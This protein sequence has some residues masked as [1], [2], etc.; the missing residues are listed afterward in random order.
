MVLRFVGARLVL[1][2][3]CGWCSGL[4]VHGWRCRECLFGVVLVGFEAIQGDKET[5]GQ[6][7][8][9]R[10]RQRERVKERERELDRGG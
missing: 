6:R 4:L 8:R 3:V 7:E 10:E 1:R 2:S 9:N 5:E